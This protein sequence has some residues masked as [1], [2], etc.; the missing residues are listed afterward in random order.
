MKIK[1]PDY[2]NSIV[3]LICS[4]LKH[5]GAEYRHN[6][7]PVFDK[8]LEKN[9]KNVVIMLFDGLGVHALETHLN[10]DS[11]L[12][13]HFEAEISSVFPPTTT[14]ATTT[15]ETGLTPTE[16][17]W[18]GWSLYFS[19]IDKIVNVFINTIKGTSEQAADYH[20]G[21]TIIPYKSVYDIINETGNAKAYSVSPYGTNKVSSYMEMFDETERLCSMDGNKYIYTYFEQPDADMHDCGYYSD[22]AAAWIEKIDRDVENMCH[23]LKDT[24]IIV[25]ADHGHI[26]LK[27]KFVSDY[28]E[29][30]EMLV[31]P[32]SIESRAACFY[33]KDEY[34]KKFADEFYKDFGHDFMLLSRQEVMEKRLFGDGRIHP[35]FQEFIGDF[36]AV[37]I[38]DTGIVNNHECHQFLSNHAGMTIQ[39]MMV[40][41]IVIET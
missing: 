30:S 37:A 4:V 34:K 40:P 15:I 17:G 16:H 32:V 33:V 18:L 29:L 28:P 5:Y 10:K 25:T 41:F 13:K 20:V 39:E 8:Y 9:Y 26:S 36:L 19:E 7:L 14:S 22:E 1:Y 21:N 24:L 38:E 31:R 6:T 2:N 27:Y 35:K 11:F 12:R 3:N 23:K